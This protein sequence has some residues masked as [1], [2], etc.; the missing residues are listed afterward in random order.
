MHVAVELEMDRS[1]LYRALDPMVRDEWVKITA[2]TDARSRRAVI[3]RRGY[4]LL[5]KAG[6]QWER[7]QTRVVERF[8][9]R[10]W[11]VFVAEVDRF[12]ESLKFL[13]PANPSKVAQKG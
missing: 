2:G 10:E 9:R 5:A 4:R 6:A 1:S 8:G 7:V 13:G 11:G 3:T 12:H